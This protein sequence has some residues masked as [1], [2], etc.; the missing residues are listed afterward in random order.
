MTYSNYL[1]SIDFRLLVFFKS[2]FQVP[3]LKKK[4]YQ[5]K[6]QNWFVCKMKQDN[7]TILI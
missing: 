5:L 7:I 2:I 4:N 1:V 6:A 3:N